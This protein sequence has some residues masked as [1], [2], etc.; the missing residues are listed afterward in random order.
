MI[1]EGRLQTVAAS[2]VRRWGEQRQ[3]RL[4]TEE[5]GECIAK[6]NQR[7][8]DR[9]TDDQ[10]AAEVADVII[11]AVQARYILGPSVDAWI[12]RK[13]DRLEMLIA[14]AEQTAVQP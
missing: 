9:A 7:E 11:T 12:A 14:D 3:L 4:L 5:C 13:L 10:L 8:R 2:A 1:L 6:V